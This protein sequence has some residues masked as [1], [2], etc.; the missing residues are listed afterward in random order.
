MANPY[1]KYKDTAIMSASKEQ[2]LLMLYEGAIRFTKLAIQA[3]EANNIPERGKN[4]M[5]AYDIVLEFQASLNHSVAGDLPRQLEQ[6]YVYM[7]EQYTKANMTGNLESLKS[8]Q[9]VLENLYDGWKQVAD[10]IKNQN[11]QN[12]GAA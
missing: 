5:R 9:N 3:A 4:I 8:C 10:K 7:L 1:K 11:D 2:V 6:L 12:G